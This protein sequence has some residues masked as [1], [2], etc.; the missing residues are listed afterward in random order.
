M[1]YVSQAV[2]N[3][4]YVIDRA[5]F[6]LSPYLTWEEAEKIA[7]ELERLATSRYEGNFTNADAFNWLAQQLGPDRY[8]AVQMLWT[9]DN[10]MAIKRLYAPEQLRAAHV[11][12]LSMCEGTPEEVKANPD[13]YIEIETLKSEYQ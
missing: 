1:T 4:F 7:V 6:A 2:T 13:Q 3:R 11:H 12:K 10:Q 9:M 5:M 8:Q